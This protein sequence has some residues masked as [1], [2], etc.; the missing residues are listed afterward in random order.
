MTQRS[1]IVA[2]TTVSFQAVSDGRVRGEWPGRQVALRDRRF[3]TEASQ[4][5]QT[6]ASG[7]DL[8]HRRGFCEGQAKRRGRPRDHGLGED[9]VPSSMVGPQI[10]EAH[11]RGLRHL[12]EGAR[13]CPLSL[14]VRLYLA[15]LTN[16]CPS[17]RKGADD[18]RGC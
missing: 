6:I 2:L 1:R 14:F 7:M 10:D 3:G 18:A 4:R 16:Y 8:P 9:P 5:S 11:S 12:P 13:S 17:S 15:D